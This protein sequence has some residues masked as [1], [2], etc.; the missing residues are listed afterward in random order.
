MKCYLWKRGRI[1]LMGQVM[2]FGRPLYER[3][4]ARQTLTVALD[5]SMDLGQRCRRINVRF[6]HCGVDQRIEF[7][8]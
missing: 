5:H 4:A 3:Y 7:E 1:R 8:E 2:F 6:C